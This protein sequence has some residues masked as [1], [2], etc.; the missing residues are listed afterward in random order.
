MPDADFAE[1]INRVRAGD[2]PAAED[3]FRR[4]EPQLRLEIRLRLRDQRLR[5]LLDE[6]DVCQSV[7]L[8]FFVRARLG[9]YDVADPGELKRLLAGMARNKVA[10]QARKQGAARRDFR[11]TEGLAGAE[12]APAAGDTP[13]Q[14]VASEELLC[15][16]R[17]RLREEERRVADLRANGRG[18]TDIATEVGG[19]PDGRRVQ[20]RRALERVAQ[21]LGLESDDE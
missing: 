15:E 20:F 14:V 7:M 17:A 9:Q 6:G 4:S 21:E 2:A 3:L 1:L 12:A 19:T 8:S 11:K 16:F 18:W 10:A 13:R 5:R